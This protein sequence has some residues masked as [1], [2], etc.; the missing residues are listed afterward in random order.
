MQANKDSVPLISQYI[1]EDTQVA[2]YFTHKEA[3]KTFNYYLKPDVTNSDVIIERKDITGLSIH[4]RE[5]LSEQYLY[6]SHTYTNNGELVE[7]NAELTFH[8]PNDN[9]NPTLSPVSPVTPHSSHDTDLCVSQSD[10]GI[11]VLN[12]TGEFVTELGGT[13][14]DA[15]MSN[16]TSPR[17]GCSPR[18]S[19][20]A[21]PR[22]SS[23]T[24]LHNGPT[25]NGYKKKSAS[26][27]SS[28][29]IKT[30][31]NTGPHSSTIGSKDSAI[32]ESS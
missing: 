14:I 9:P 31:S 28:P 1:V 24:H 23:P 30:H 21:S 4:E 5:D 20:S 27:D 10:S 2:L 6:F 3:S 11:Q 19:P 15:S 25:V 32:D 22:M 18:L 12:D 29:I 16:S 26:T 13:M 8:P 17:R 7:E